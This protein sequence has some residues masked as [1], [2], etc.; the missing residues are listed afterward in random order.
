MQFIQ[1]II[2]ILQDHHRPCD[3]NSPCRLQLFPN[4]VSVIKED[5]VGTALPA[6]VRKIAGAQ[7]MGEKDGGLSLL[8]LLLQLPPGQWNTAAIGGR[9]KKV[10]RYTLHSR[11]PKRPAASSKRFCREPPDKAEDT[12]IRA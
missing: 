12:M 3:T 1:H 2:H 4:G 11:D 8:Q 6:H 10:L 7:L 9:K 5:K